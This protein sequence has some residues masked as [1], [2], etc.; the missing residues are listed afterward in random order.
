MDEDAALEQARRWGLDPLHLEKTLHH[1]HVFTHIEW[2]MCCFVIHC[3]R[4][5]GPFVWALPEELAG[6]YAIPSA[7][8]YF[9]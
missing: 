3:A 6:R 8:R 5:E 4:Q 1:R 9:L 2:H 7:F